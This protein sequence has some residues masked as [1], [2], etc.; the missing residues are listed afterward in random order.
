MTWYGTWA[1]TFTL[2]AFIEENDIWNRPIYNSETG[3]QVP[4]TYITMFQFLMGRQGLPMG[5]LLV[6]FCMALALTAFLSFHFYIMTI[7]GMTTNEYFKWSQVKKWHSIN[8]KKYE[9]AKSAGNA[10]APYNINKVNTSEAIG[11]HQHKKVS[12]PTYTMPELPDVDVGCAGV[13]ASYKADQMA[14][15]SKERKNVFE[16]ETTEK[17][18]KDAAPIH[19]ASKLPGVDVGRTGAANSYKVDQGEVTSEKKT[20]PLVDDPGP[21]PKNIYNL[22]LLE[23]ITEVISP[24]SLREDAQERWLTYLKEH[25]KNIISDRKKVQEKKRS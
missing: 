11:K 15:T 6:N 19:S 1:V 18:D 9:E 3:E 5:V 23:N 4:T 22:G 21:L 20:G 13:G 2:K 7:L 17:F 24:R 8:V 16:T 25:G 12:S 10:G 14:R